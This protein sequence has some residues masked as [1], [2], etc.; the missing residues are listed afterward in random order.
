MDIVTEDERRLIDEA[1]ARIP[2][3]QRRVPTGLSGMDPDYVWDPDRKQIVTR[4]ELFKG[5]L[6]AKPR[7][8]ARSL[9]ER[10]K[11][12]EIAR[13]IKDGLNLS[14]IALLRNTSRLRI[15]RVAREDGLEIAKPVPVRRQKSVSGDDEEIT[16]KVIALADGTRGL[17]EIARLAGCHKDAVKLR[18]DRLGLDIPAGKRRAVA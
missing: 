18:R 6:R 13:D 3:D 15:H 9:P 1:L 14:E 10:L 5:G 7:K 12:R 2:E 17:T 8:E 4:N 16:R 11:D